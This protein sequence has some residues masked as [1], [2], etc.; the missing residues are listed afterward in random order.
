MPE[1]RTE[2]Q[3]CMKRVNRLTALVFLTAGITHSQQL[4][5]TPD[6]DERHAMDQLRTIA[7]AI[8][9]CPESKI[10]SNDGS[11]SYISAP[12]N[13]VWDIEQSSSARSQK[14]GY[15]EYIEH[16]SYISPPQEVCKKRDQAC[17]NRNEATHETNLI[18]MGINSPDQFRLEFDIGPSGIEFR[19]GLMK[20]QSDDETRWLARQ[21]RNDCESKAVSIIHKVE[22]P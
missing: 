4:A 18:M 11:G 17:N 1:S 9:G 13:V 5:T 16:S 6:S 10:M 15:I 20:H 22:K 14:I 19:R 3:D 7:E 8:K 21:L 12:F 2:R